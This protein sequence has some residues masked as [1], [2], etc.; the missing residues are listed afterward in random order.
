MSGAS[1]WRE[2]PDS[3]PGGLTSERSY[4]MAMFNLR[5]L[6]RNLTSCHA[7]PVSTYGTPDPSDKGERLAWL[8]SKLPCHL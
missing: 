5:T 4:S 6:I 8:L 2:N 7:N 3:N 1:Q